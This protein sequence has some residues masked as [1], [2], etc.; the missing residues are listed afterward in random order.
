MFVAYDN[1]LELVRALV[2]V[3]KVV[4]EHSS[5]VALQLE[6]AV[7]SIV[8]NIGEGSKRHGKDPVRFY[9]MA[10]GSASEVRAC[11]DLAEA[12]G[13]SVNS[14]RARE[15]VE[16]QLRLLYGLTKSARVTKPRGREPGR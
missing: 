10:D 12:F 8:L 1:A 5:E 15:L 11:L 3:I 14:E 7:T 9:I 6:R 13:W 16:R 2:P 4:R